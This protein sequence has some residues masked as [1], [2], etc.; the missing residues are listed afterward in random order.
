ML[1]DIANDPSIKPLIQKSQELTCFIYNHGWALSIMRTETQ[2][3]ELVRPAITRFATNFFALDSIL[4][5]QA[6]LKW[7][8]NTRGWAENYM[9]LN[10]KDREKTNVVVGL[11]DSQTYWR[12][13]AGVTAIFGPLVK[14][15]R[16]V[17]S[18]DKAEMGHIYEAM[19]RAKFMIK[20]NVG[21]G[22][23]KCWQMI[24]KRWNNQLHQ[25]IH[26]A[27]KLFLESQVP[28]C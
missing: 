19:D 17:D 25:D 2:N 16:M 20:K 28:I 9:K 12:N 18:D 7:M 1:K 27:D 13:I 22:Y 5:H 26:A 10:R 14:V 24:D 11:I 23:K 8:T 6:D 3:G 4:T 21:K 15:L